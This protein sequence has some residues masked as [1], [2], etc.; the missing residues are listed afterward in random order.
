MIILLT[1]LCIKYV[2]TDDCRQVWYETLCLVLI[3][4]LCVYLFI[5][6]LRD[7]MRSGIY[8]EFPRLPDSLI[9]DSFISNKMQQN[10]DVVTSC[11]LNSAPTVNS[12]KLKKLLSRIFHNVDFVKDGCILIT[13]VSSIILC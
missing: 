11:H 3:K 5:I 2:T 12:G 1:C 7:Q 9:T 13:P 8:T 10:P 6:E 4:D